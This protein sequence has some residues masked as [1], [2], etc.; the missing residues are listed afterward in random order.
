MLFLTS[1]S[2]SSKKTPATHYLCKTFCIWA[3]VIPLESHSFLHHFF[4]ARKEF[5]CQV[6]SREDRDKKTEERI[7][8][9]AWKTKAGRQICAS[10]T[11]PFQ[12]LLEPA[13]VGPDSGRVSGPTLDQVDAMSAV[14]DRSFLIEEPVFYLSATYIVQCAHQ[15]QVVFCAHSNSWNTICSFAP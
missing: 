7:W 14:P 11:S 3:A 12:F 8:V 15:R 2:K 9:G 13:T 5:T 6:C 4:F 1:F 10:G